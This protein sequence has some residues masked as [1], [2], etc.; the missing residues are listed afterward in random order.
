MSA[1][2]LALA[3]PSPTV[4]KST[5]PKVTNISMIAMSRPRSPTRLTKNALLAGAR[6]GRVPVPEADEQ[7]RGQA[8]ALPA[9]EQQQVGVGE[10]EQQHR[11]DE[12][13]E[14]GE[15]APLVGV[16]LHVA[17]R[18]HVDERPDEGDQHD[19]AHR[20]RVDEQADVELEGARRDPVPQREVHRPLLGRQADELEQ[21]DQADDERG[22]G[23]RRCRGSAPIL[24]VRRPPSRRIAAPS[25]GSAMSSHA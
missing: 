14:V 18:V 13:V 15:E 10:H 24:S 22:P 4:A 9:D 21:H 5:P 20:Q 3:T 23:H 19:E 7:V 6:V 8:H 25:S 2:W 11:G 17:D 1:P 12:E 16:V